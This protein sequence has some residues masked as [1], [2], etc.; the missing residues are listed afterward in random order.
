MTVAT[1]GIQHIVGKVSAIKQRWEGEK[2]DTLV[3]EIDDGS[4]L[5]SPISAKGKEHKDLSTV[6]HVGGEF[7]F[8]VTAE[9]IGRRA[10]LQF[11]SFNSSALRTRSS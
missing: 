4:E 3:I 5:G 11:R 9:S 6:L 1:K 2:Y 8:L 10:A 7:A